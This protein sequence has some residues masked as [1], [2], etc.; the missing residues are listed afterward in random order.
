MIQIQD[1]KE[2]IDHLKCRK[3]NGQTGRRPA[4]RRAAIRELNFVMKLRNKL[5]YI[6]FVLLVS[7]SVLHAEEPVLRKKPPYKGSS[8]RTF[9]HMP[10]A[11][12]VEGSPEWVFWKLMQAS[13]KMDF[14]ELAKYQSPFGL[15]GAKK[16][17]PA[18]MAVFTSVKLDGEVRI[19]DSVY[20]GDAC[21]V[22]MGF[23][24]ET[25]DVWLT[26]YRYFLKV[27]GVWLCVNSNEWQCG[28]L[29][30]VLSSK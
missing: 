19:D 9:R 13:K 7:V 10:V 22:Y 15:S 24:G 26:A 12:L 17:T 21:Y 30:A 14:V 2:F 23:Q 28:K 1:G 20:D 4:I 6:L 29:D 27:N 18:M 5:K 11:D 25:S 16:N 3:N 8:L